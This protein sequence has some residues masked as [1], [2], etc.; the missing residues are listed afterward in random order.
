MKE[1][2]PGSSRPRD[3]L[4]SLSA[5]FQVARRTHWPTVALFLVI[6]ALV[7]VNAVL[8]DRWQGFDAAD[9]LNYIRALATERD[10]P[11]CQDTGQGY[12]PPAMRRS[13]LGFVHR[14]GIG[15]SPRTA[16]LHYPRPSS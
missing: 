16:E 10:I 3:L 15:T 4:T 13:R 7:L 1:A 9:D 11:T 6:N 14:A 2:R 5:P 8:H 12:V